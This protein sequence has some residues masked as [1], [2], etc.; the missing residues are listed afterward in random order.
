[1]PD[2]SEYPEQAEAI[3]KRKSSLSEKFA[4]DLFG[5]AATPV[6]DEQPQRYEANAEEEDNE[7]NIETLE[8][9]W[10]EDDE[11]NH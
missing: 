11:I 5:S 3:R 1:V 4:P 10:E 7:E 9:D 2:P 6:T 8:D